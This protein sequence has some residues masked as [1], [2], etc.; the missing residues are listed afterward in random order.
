MFVNEWQLLEGGDLGKPQFQQ[1]TKF[2]RNTK[3]DLTI[4][5]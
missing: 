2:C 3:L 1:N 4:V 5:L